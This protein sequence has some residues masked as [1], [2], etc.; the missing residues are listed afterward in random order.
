MTSKLD[1]LLENGSWTHDGAAAL[2]NWFKIH[3]DDFEAELN[4][5]FLADNWIEYTSA[6]EAAEEHG[7][8]AP[9]EDEAIAWLRARTIAVPF[10]GGV[11]VVNF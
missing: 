4:V 8:A 9:D 7:H 5:S 1:L 10:H 3:E 11:I 6:L 2:L